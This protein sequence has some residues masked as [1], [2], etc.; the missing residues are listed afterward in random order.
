MK[1]KTT[2]TSM[3]SWNELVETIVRFCKNTT[4]QSPEIFCEH[5]AE[6]L[7]ICASMIRTSLEKRKND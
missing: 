4:R 7:E 2:I 1:N 6:Q 5:D 3:V